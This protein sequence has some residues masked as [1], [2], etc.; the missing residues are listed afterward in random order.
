MGHPKPTAVEIAEGKPRQHA[1]NAFE[2][3]FDAV[4]PDCPSHLSA[5]AERRW[6]ELAPMLHRAKLLTEA[7]QMALADLCQCY[8]TMAKAQR[9][10]N[11]SSLLQKTGEGT[12]RATPLFKIIMDSM[13]MIN[14]L[15]CEFGLTPSSRSRLRVDKKEKAT[16]PL[17]DA[18]FGR[19]ADLL[20]LPKRH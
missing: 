17:D 6:N 9:Q 8:A 2:P 13:A 15:C 12:M 18:I 1:V 3:E 11:K 5:E 4:V 14:R 19:S 10:L 20:V 7:D 16:D